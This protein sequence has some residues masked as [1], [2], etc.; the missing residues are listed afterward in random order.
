MARSQGAQQRSCSS[1]SPGLQTV[2]LCTPPSEH[3][4]AVQ[5]ATLHAQLLSAL[6]QA[7]GRAPH[8]QSAKK[9]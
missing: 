5:E 9:R 2:V 4:L 1:V 8:T 6:V 3:S 7:Q